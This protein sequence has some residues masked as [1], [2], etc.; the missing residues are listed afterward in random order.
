MSKT[1]VNNKSD[2]P[3]YIMLAIKMIADGKV[4]NSGFKYKYKY[5]IPEREWRKNYQQL[6]CSETY[7]SL[8][9]SKYKLH[10]MLDK[11]SDHP[12]TINNSSRVN[13]LTFDEE[14]E[15]E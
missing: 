12:F 7:I 2:V 3:E 11:I 8:N 14:S 4:V 10:E 9:S 6:M 15:D 5:E 13:L 1:T